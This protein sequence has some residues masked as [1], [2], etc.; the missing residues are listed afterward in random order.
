MCAL[1]DLRSRQIDA[2]HAFDVLGGVKFVAQAHT[3]TNEPLQAGSTELAAHGEQV[4]TNPS[5]R[6]DDEA[7]LFPD[8]ERA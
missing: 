5:L 3:G 8:D 6:L 4:D 1:C 7:S 2:K